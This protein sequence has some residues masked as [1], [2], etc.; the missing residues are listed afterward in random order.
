MLKNKK[1]LGF[2]ILSTVLSV[3]SLIISLYLIITMRKNE[4]TAYLDIYQIG[5]HE[6]IDYDV[7][8]MYYDS[9]WH[10]DYRGSFSGD[11][12]E[13]TVNNL[14]EVLQQASFQKTSEPKEDDAASNSY[15]YVVLTVNNNRYGIAAC[16]GKLKIS[17][18]GTAAYYNTCCSNQIKFLLKNI[19]EELFPL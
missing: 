10:P 16:N 15:A 3:A 13:K 19:E 2:Y 8:D 17:I 12:V 4:E 18:N 5:L 14:R 6:L 7:T 9:G 1:F 11:E